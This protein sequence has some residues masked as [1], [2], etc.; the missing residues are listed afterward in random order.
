MFF[1][2]VN[3]DPGLTISGALL[4]LFRN[5]VVPSCDALKNYGLCTPVMKKD[6]ILSLVMADN[7][8][9]SKLFNFIFVRNHCLHIVFLRFGKNSS[10]HR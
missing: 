3:V 2:Q 6:F 9:L 5:I 7:F 8:F 10:K 4:E 1:C